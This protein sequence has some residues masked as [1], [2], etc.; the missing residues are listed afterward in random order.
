MKTVLIPTEDHDSMSA[1]LE[2]ARLIA[3]RFDSYMEGFAVRPSS[4]DFVTFEPVSS[5]NMSSV[6]ESEPR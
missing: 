1:V 5:L 6:A 4:E 2:T 3:N